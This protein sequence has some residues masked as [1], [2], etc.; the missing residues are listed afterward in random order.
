METP[1]SLQENIY[2]GYFPSSDETVVD[3]W[4]QML[5]ICCALCPFLYILFGCTNETGHASSVRLSVIVGTH[6]PHVRQSTCL[7]V[8]IKSEGSE[9]W[10]IVIRTPSL[11]IIVH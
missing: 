5:T 11:S 1:I 10:E 2:T 9:E 7:T 6:A 4:D 3:R 8:K